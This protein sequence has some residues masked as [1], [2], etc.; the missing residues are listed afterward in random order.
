MA[1]TFSRFCPQCGKSVSA[2]Q[3][4]CAYCSQPLDERFVE[5]G[6]MPSNVLMAETTPEAQKAT[7]RLLNS[8][9]KS[10][11]S[12]LKG[13]AATV[14]GLAVVGAGVLYGTGL[15]HASALTKQAA[16]AKP[17]QSQNKQMDSIMSILTVART[18]E[19]LAVTFYSNGI[20]NAAKLGLSGDNLAYIQAAL[21]E[22]QIHQL[23]FAANGG[24]SLAETFSFPQGAQTFTDLKTFI[25]TQQQLE[26]VFDSAFLAAVAEFAQLGRPDLA[27]ISA[28]V[29]CI[30]AEHRALGRSI[31][32]LSPADNWAF[33][34]VMVSSVGAAPALVKSAG[35]LSP[36]SGNS[37]TYKQVSTDD[38]G[39]E[40][41]KPY[42]INTT[43]GNG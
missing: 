32:G 17:A 14:G 38:A 21:V 34:P 12:L 19:Q 27:Q 39:V 16:P 26:G 4:F 36:T 28:Q 29:A 13:A 24:Q 8:F 41:R 11:R 25:S 22:E 43:V 18:A 42:S 2:Q 37:Y 7:A 35:Y 3:H 20:S 9:P 10:R 5:S 40:Q 31:G 33:T 15:T 30:E 1:A 23:F 6:V